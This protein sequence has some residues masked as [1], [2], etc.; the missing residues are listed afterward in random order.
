MGCRPIFKVKMRRRHATLT[1]KY[2]VILI[3]RIASFDLEGGIIKK[4]LQTNLATNVVHAVVGGYRDI[5]L[6]KN[7][8][9]LQESDEFI[10][11][12]VERGKR[13]SCLFI[14]SPFFVLEDVGTV[15]SDERESRNLFEIFLIEQPLNLLHRVL[16]YLTFPVG[17]KDI[18][19]C[20]Y[21]RA[22]IFF[23]FPPLNF[24]IDRGRR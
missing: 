1:Y 13:L 15:Q 7:S 9:F 20:R 21:R 12:P 10:Q 16:I 4:R 23:F 3:T 22:R 14:S 6:F 19:E 11:R 17:Y 5:G 8:P 24:G 2:I 18:E